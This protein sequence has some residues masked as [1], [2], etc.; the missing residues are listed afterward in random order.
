VRAAVIARP[1]G[2]EG[3]GILGRIV[4][5]GTV[6]G[7][8]VDAD[9]GLIMRKRLTVVGTVLRSRPS[10]EK[11]AL[12]RDFERSVLP[13]LADGR[14]RPVVDRVLP[15]ESAPAAHAAMEANENF[16]KIVLRVD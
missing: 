8:R 3:L 2:P 13:L 5:V 9:L 1:G 7:S 11:I 12:A 14:I 15:L 16:G 6:S 4:L 10:A